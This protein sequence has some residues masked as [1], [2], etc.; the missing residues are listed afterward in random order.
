MRIRYSGQPPWIDGRPGPDL[1]K[2]RRR[3]RGKARWDSVRAIRS[4]LLNLTPVEY[5]PVTEP[6]HTAWV[7]AH[8]KT[9]FQVRGFFTIDMPGIV[10]REPVDNSQS[11]PPSGLSAAVFLFLNFPV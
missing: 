4:R 5:S 2:E 9:P 7:S 1:F 11:L 3:G 8:K 10:M 6:R